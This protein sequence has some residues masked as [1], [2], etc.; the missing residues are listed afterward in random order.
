MQRCLVVFLV[1]LRETFL[2]LNGL[3]TM[4]KLYYPGIREIYFSISLIWSTTCL[5]VGLQALAFLKKSFDALN[6]RLF[7]KIWHMLK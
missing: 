6:S 3:I 4:Y 5:V 1:A 7:I 2:Q